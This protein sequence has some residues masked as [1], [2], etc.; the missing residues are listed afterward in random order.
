[1]EEITLKTIATQLGISISTVSRALRNHP[2][3]KDSTKQAVFELAEQLEYEPNQLAFQLLNR[4]SNTIGVVVPKITYSLYAQAIPGMVDVSERYGY[5]L[6]ICQTDDSYE[7]EVRQVQSLLSSR[8]SGIILSVSASTTQFDHLRK[9]QS[10]NVPLV[11]F[12]RDCEEIN[13]SK[14]TIDNHKAAFEAVTVLIRQG[15]KRIAYLGGPT[16]LQISQKR[17]EGYQQ[18]L[19]EG[20]FSPDDA[21]IN[22]VSLEKE[23]MLATLNAVLDS[24]EKPDAILAYSDQIAQ[25][26]LVMAKRKGIRIPEELAI[27][28]FYNEPTN[29]LLDPPLSSVSQPAFEMGV[30]AVE[31][32]FSELTNSR[33]AFERV[34]LE[35]KLIVRGSI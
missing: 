4:R 14:V 21:L 12:N 3:I 32:I 22:M 23:A 11:L 9:I 1:M 28:G 34:V 5:Q 31:L 33:A 16:D 19:K 18:A 2:D 25:W 17:L 35:S 29:E 13:C 24:P 6:L 8:V 15:R 30:R 26:A 10:K 27:I 20:G 7:K